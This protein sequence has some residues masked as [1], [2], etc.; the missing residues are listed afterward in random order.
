[1]GTHKNKSHADLVIAIGSEFFHENFAGQYKY[2]HGMQ[3]TLSA[4][5]DAIMLL[6]N[7]ELAATTD[8]ADWADELPAVIAAQDKRAAEEAQT[9]RMKRP[10][11]AATFMGVPYR[12]RAL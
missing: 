3:P 4:V 1:M 5:T 8:G 10:T 11:P 6:G 7:L 9:K 12:A 2:E